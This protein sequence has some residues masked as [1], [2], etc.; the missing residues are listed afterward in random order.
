MRKGSFFVKKN[1]RVF[2]VVSDYRKNDIQKKPILYAAH[3]A[4][5]LF[6]HVTLMPS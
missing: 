3:A 4:Q 1:S 5:L 2:R 6:L